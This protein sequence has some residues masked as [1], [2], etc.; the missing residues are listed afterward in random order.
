MATPQDAELILKLYELRQEKTLREARKFIIFDFFPR[1]ADDVKALFL[2]REHPEYNAYFRQA[3]SYWDMAAAMVNHG[4]IDRELF[5]ATNG[6]FLAIWAKFDDFIGELRE[7]TGANTMANLEK[8]VAAHPDR[9]KRI[10][11]MKERYKILAAIHAEK[12]K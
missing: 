11:A 7:F 2:D 12:E 8:L 1:S 6:E 3:T 4:T 5:F 10:S 9:E